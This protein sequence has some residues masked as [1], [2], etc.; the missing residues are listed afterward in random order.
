MT[1][2]LVIIGITGLQG[3]SVRKVF[4]HEPEWR[5]RGITRN[6]SKHEALHKE[7]IELVSANLDDQ[8]SLDKAFAGANAIFAVT[9]FWQFLKDGATF[10]TAE[11]AGNKPNEVAM[12]L[13]VQQ[14]KNI[15]QAAAKQLGTLERLVL[16]TLSDSRKWSKGEIKW[17]LHFDGKAH[18]TQY[19][20]DQYP[21]LAKKTSYLQMG[22][23]LS[24]W[25][26]LPSFKPAKQP[27]GSF[28]ISNFARLNGKPLPYVDPPNDTGY[29]VHALVLSPKAPPGTTMLGYCELRTAEDYCALW[30]K[31]LGKDCTFKHL[32]FDNAKEEGM[33]EW[34]ALEVSESGSY[35]TKYGWGGGDPEVRHPVD[36]GVNVNK[37]TKVEDWI[38]REDWSSVL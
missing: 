31:I 16:S 28:I 18:F 2:L 33:P 17:N 11:K 8:E 27:D 9:D 12:Q 5:I 34:M 20:K 1:K 37:L 24:N 38:K 25:N 13:E 10:E 19:L 15:I 7:G 4:Q 36:C 30:G 6:P 32:T 29:F 26:M 35:V 14:G 3:S 23:Y 22:W 21:D